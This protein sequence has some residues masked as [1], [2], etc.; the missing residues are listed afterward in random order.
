M[1]ERG[2]KMLDVVLFTLFL[3]D[4]MFYHIY[5]PPITIPFLCLPLSFHCLS[6]MCAVYYRMTLP[7][8]NIQ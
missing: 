2:M 7:P 1:V 5:R 4:D 8:F 3:P 6:S